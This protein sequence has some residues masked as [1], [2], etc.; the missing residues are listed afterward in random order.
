MKTR[1]GDNGLIDQTGI[2]QKHVEAIT[3]GEIDKLVHVICDMSGAG[4]YVSVEKLQVRSL[5]SVN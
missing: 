2:C 3:S 5:Q 4:D 1:N